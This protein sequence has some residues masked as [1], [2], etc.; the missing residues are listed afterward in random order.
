MADYPRVFAQKRQRLLAF[1]PT[2]AQSRYRDVYATFEASVEIIQ[3]TG[4]EA[5]A[6][7]LQLLPVLATFDSNRLPLPLFEAGWKGAR[8]YMAKLNSARDYDDDAGDADDTL[9][10]RAWHTSRLLLLM[11]VGDRQWDPYR[12]IEAVDLLKSFSLVSTDTHSGFLSVS[13]HPL[14]HA[15]A[16]DRQDSKEQNT[17]WITSGCIIA[18]SREDRDF[19][20]QHSRQLR[21]HLHALVAFETSKLFVCCPA[22][23]VTAILLQCGWLLYDMKDSAL[24]DSLMQGLF[25]E[26]GLNMHTMKGEWLNIYDLTARNLREYGKPSRAVLLLDQIVR[27]REQRLPAYD[28]D[29]LTSQHELARAYQANGQILEAIILL[30]G[31]VKIKEQILDNDH[32]DLLSSQHELASAYQNNGRVQEAMPL[33]E[34]VV[35]IRDETLPENHPDLLTSQHELAY[36]YQ[37]NGRVQEAMPLLES[38]VKIRGE[39]LPE[40]HPDRLTSEYNLAGYYWDFG[41]RDTAFEMMAHVVKIRRQVNNEDHAERLKSQHNLATYHWGLGRRN[42][43][44][45]LMAC[46]V[47]IRRQVLPEH[48]VSRINS[49]KWLKLFQKELSSTGVE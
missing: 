39:T 30:E 34:S 29:L 19:W 10:M 45:D 4:T 12:L 24:V 33:L 25:S 31:A 18:M 16:R 5:A 23:K 3:S 21:P 42:V 49:E 38:V 6:D 41:R 44:F 46:V 17:S 48:H 22:K 1:H 27:F 40:D 32:P 15:W 43:A 47:K 36:A 11:E 13:M 7:A 28:N 37:N 9:N 14:V 35:K 8:P 20:L 26:L 2:Q